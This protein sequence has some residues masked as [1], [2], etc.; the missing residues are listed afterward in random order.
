MY[1][2]EERERQKRALGI[3]DGLTDTEARVYAAKVTSQSRELAARTQ[4]E[5]RELAISKQSETDALSL[6]EKT[7]QEER[8]A[9]ADELIA[10]LSGEN[11]LALRKLDSELLPEELNLRH[12]HRLKETLSTALAN[13]LET[14]LI[15]KA[16]N[17]NLT[18]STNEQ[19]RLEAART[20]EQI[21]LELFRLY[22]S[23]CLENGTKPSAKTFEEWM[24]QVTE[25][26]DIF[27]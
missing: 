22:A 1:S 2:W 13:A 21:R 20:N 25:N 14:V 6:R 24:A 12:R 9:R 17:V 11:A 15:E 3:P 26:E 5:S 19:I 8:R 7:K 27:K 4:A 16:R 23:M 10:Q 18:H